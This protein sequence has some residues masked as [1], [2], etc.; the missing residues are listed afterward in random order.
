MGCVDYLFTFGEPVFHQS[1]FVY[2]LTTIGPNGFAN[3]AISISGGNK[4]RNQLVISPW[5]E[6]GG[7][8]AN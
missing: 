1:R 6:A 2:E 4:A 3:F 7:F 5:F 8:Q